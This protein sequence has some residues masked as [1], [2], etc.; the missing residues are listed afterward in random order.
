[1]GSINENSDEA[2]SFSWRTKDLVVKFILN[3]KGAPCIEQVHSP[4][5]PHTRNVSPYF[6][7]ASVPLNAIRINGRGHSAAK[8]SKSL[9]GGVLSSQLMYR[10]HFQRSTPKSDCLDIVSKDDLTGI[11]ADHSGDLP[12]W[13]C[14][15][16][17][18]DRSKHI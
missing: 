1:M 12:R 15:S 11:E 7:S 5:A 6:G 14:A 2:K 9:V 10:G 16:E 4:G 8:T 13:A 17:L 18:H 3:D